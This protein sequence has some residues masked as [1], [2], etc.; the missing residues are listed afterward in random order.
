MF[1]LINDLQLI[2]DNFIKISFLAVHQWFKSLCKNRID[3]IPARTSIPTTPLLLCI[4]CCWRMVYTI[5]T[6]F[7][8]RLGFPRYGRPSL[9]VLVLFQAEKNVNKLSTSNFVRLARRPRRCRPYLSFQLQIIQSSS[10]AR[11][12]SSLE[13]KI[14]NPTFKI[15]SSPLSTQKILYLSN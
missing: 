3:H 10:F 4:L 11:E 14:K 9:V 12:R 5:T 6:P 1:K 13:S 7:W 2:F 15:A 8:A